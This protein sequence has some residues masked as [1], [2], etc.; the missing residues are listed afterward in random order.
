MS[1]DWKEVT[2][3]DLLNVA[4]NQSAEVIARYQRIM[5]KK[6]IDA[7][8]QVW[9]GL[10]DVKKSM[11]I[12]S[13]KLEARLREAEAI[14]KEAATSQGKLQRVT[15]ALTVVIAI[16]T[17]AYTWITWQSVQAQREANQIQREAR[18]AE[19]TAKL[20][21]PSNPTIERAR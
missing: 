2:D 19:A 13:E 1:K 9:M 12:A 8:M 15:I 21:S 20:E 4:G 18:D 14:Q 7:L 5:D 16:S 17:V 10:I 3:D 11:Q 6:T